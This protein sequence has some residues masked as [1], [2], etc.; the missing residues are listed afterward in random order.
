MENNEK[1]LGLDLGTNS[2]GWAIIERTQSGECNLLNRGTNTFEKGVTI[3]KSGEVPSVKERTDARGA[4]TQGCHKRSRKISVLK[5]L[6]KYALCPEL[7]EADL[8]QWKLKKIY[9]L[10]PDFL[11]W[12]RTDDKIDKNPYNDRYQCLTRTLDLSRESERFM[13]G[14]A[15]YHIAQRRGFL[16]NRKTRTESSDGAVSQGI[17][18]L[19]QEI[20]DAQ[21][22]YLGEYYYQLYQDGKKIRHRY[23]DRILHYEKEFYAICDKQKLEADVTKELYDAIFFQYP[24][25]SQRGSVA[26]CTF[27][28]SKKCC[29]ISHPLFEEFR[30]LCFINNIKIKSGDLDYR[31]LNDDEKQKIQPLFFRKSKKHFEFADIATAILGKKAR[32]ASKDEQG[33]YDFRFNFRKETS[34]TGCTTIASLKTLFGNEWESELSSQYVKAE[35]KSQD[36]IVNDVWH[37]LYSFDSDEKAKQWAMQNLQLN[38]KDATSFAKIDVIPGYASLSLKAIRK[39]IVYL[40]KGLRYDEAVLLANVKSVLPKYILEE[41]LKEIEQ[42]LI[43]EMCDFRTRQYNKDFT[44]RDSIKSYLED[45][46]GVDLSKLDKIYHPSMIEAYEDA[47]PDKDGLVLLGSPRISSI[48]NPMV[49]RALFRLRHLINTLIKENKIDQYTKVNIE[50]S[51]ELNDA[52]KRKA[53]QDYQKEQEKLRAKAR[54][55]I[56][57]FFADEYGKEI[58]PTEN[59]IDKYI[60]WDEQNHKCLYTG[61]EIGIGDFLGRNPSFDIEHTVPRSRGG[62]NSMMNKTLCD[63]RFNREVKRTMLPSQ[64]SNYAEVMAYVDEQKWGAKIAKFEKEI[65]GA[66]TS[67][68]M[69]KEAK[70]KVIVKRHIAKMKL[71]Y[72]RGKLQRFTMTEV[73]EGFSNRQGVDTGII[74][75][76]ARLY[77]KSYFN[78]SESQVFTV[79]GATT[80]EFRKLWG[81]QDEYSQKDRS[82]NSHH[83]IDAIVI[84]CIGR[85]EY[86]EWAEYKTSEEYY[87]WNN[88]NKPIL[89]K[90]WA[91][92]TQDVK[93]IADELLIY[94]YV[95]D[96]MPR[97]TKKVCKHISARL[98]YD[99]QS[100]YYSQGDSARAT[101]HDATFYGA[102]KV[103]DEI[104]YVKRVKLTDLKE[105]DIKNIVDGVVR[106]KVEQA[107]NEH[108]FKNLCSAPV[109]MNEE[110]GV[111]IK[112]VRIYTSITNPISLKKHRDVSTYEHKQNYYVTNDSNYC[113]CIYEGKDKKGKTA[114][115]VVVENNIE[116]AKRFQNENPQLRRIPKTDEKGYTL[117]YVLKIGTKVLFY[118]KSP[119]ELLSCTE[120]ELSL[121]LYK[122]YGLWTDYRI[123]LTNVH[124]TMNRKPIGGA[125]KQGEVYRPSVIVSSNQ[126]NA[127]IEG[128]HFKMSESG[129]ITFLTH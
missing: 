126:F 79:K 21:C 95:A 28:P 56:M 78:K 51:R 33:D 36:D 91:T 89:R 118:E 4:R 85:R 14:R 59:D 129:E 64:L 40:R 65:S 82:N 100:K 63:A 72:W 111:E 122:V 69:S 127:L 101:L 123:L 31:F 125:W 18:S 35:G 75:R 117:K 52:N 20:K 86:Q 9:P 77:L 8:K 99:K 67:P 17:N 55:D 97:K 124:E 68:S 30:M 54:E 128:V 6:I 73:P 115:N 34:V 7:S 92:F 93:K 1:V 27:E 70:D 11:A 3:T 107:V 58:E 57:K 42:D 43:R 47:K 119:K 19:S 121:R 61:V 87:K 46:Q 48:R 15:L 76:Y 13:L 84:A 38:E 49:M 53:I 29:P 41:K 103:D 88:G 39:I 10:N 66:R 37:V 106:A 112:K 50:F 83:C 16:S 44:K 32:Y 114:R 23:S 25:K 116:A 81:L 94:N 12:Q 120:S 71:D 105:S 62:D 60:L 24:L 22:E 98:Q 80:A 104:R 5:V 108:G 26:H 113:L 102:I 96:N 2:I 45:V 74:T 90:P 109:W 110:K